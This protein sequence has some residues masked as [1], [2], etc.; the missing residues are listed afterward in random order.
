VDGT[1]P[2]AADFNGNYQA[3]NN[4]IGSS[5]AISAWAIGELPYASATNTLARLSPGA[6]GTYLT[7]GTSIPAWGSP[8]IGGCF[9]S[10]NGSD[11]TNDIDVTV[12]ARFSDD[13]AF[14]SRH[15][16]SL[17]TAL[18]KQLDAAWAVGTNAGMRDTGSIANGTWH[19]FLIMRPDTGVVDVLASTSATSP[20]MPASYTKKWRIG[21]ILRESAT[22]IPF[23]QDLD[24]FLRTAPALDV[25]LTGSNFGTSAISRTLSVPTGIRVHAFGTFF[26]NDTTQSTYM[27]L[28]DLGAN[29]DAATTTSGRLI[30]GGPTTVGGAAAFRI[31]T[32]TS[33]QIR[34]RAAVT[35]A[36]TNFYLATEGWIDRYVL[37][38]V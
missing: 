27:L 32:N 17:T 8:A 11:A 18:T 31:R 10:N 5:T 35:S 16:M 36:G 29:D 9:L 22:I 2:V 34:S 7:M 28:S 15:Y 6:S 4:A 33:G 26:H 14:A 30:E 19:I 1:I 12:G 23:T 13:A 3:L 20:T 24:Y 37:G 25:N 38:G 21:S